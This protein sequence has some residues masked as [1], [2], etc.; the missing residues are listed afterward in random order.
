MSTIKRY[1]SHLSPGVIVSLVA[2][3]LHYRGRDNHR[4]RAPDRG[5]AA[6]TFFVSEFLQPVATRQES[7]W[8]QATAARAVT[9]HFQAGNDNVKLALALDL[10]FQPVKQITLKFH[11]LAATQA[12]HVDMIALR[13]T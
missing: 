13:A 8:E 10:A 2:T 12:G 4:R 11:D 1:N 5:Q 3:K 6:E 7:S 9:A